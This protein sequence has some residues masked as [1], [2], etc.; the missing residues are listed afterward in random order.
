MLVP[1]PVLA[2]GTRA[3]LVH[4]A[5]GSGSMLYVAPPPEQFQ[6][7]M[8]RKYR[9]WLSPVSVAGTENTPDPLPLNVAD[10]TAAALVPSVPY[11]VPAS[12]HWPDPAGVVFS[13][14]MLARLV[15][16]FLYRTYQSW[17]AALPRVWVWAR[18]PDSGGHA[19]PMVVPAVALAVVTRLTLVHW[20]A[21]SGSTR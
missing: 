11:R 13:I 17:L 18:P 6:L 14:R 2:L 16:G 12:A 7:E 1:A 8:S 20:A 21:G 19:L 15:P 3:G 4:W 10:W 5:A 9:P